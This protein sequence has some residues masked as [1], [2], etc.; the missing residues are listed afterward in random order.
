MPDAAWAVS[1]I[2]QADPGGMTTLFIALSATRRNS[3]IQVRRHA[4]IV[5]EAVTDG[6]GTYWP[7]V[8]GSR[9][10][11]EAGRDGF[12]LARW[13]VA[14]GIEAHG[15][16]SAEHF[17]VGTSTSRQR[18]IRIDAAMGIACFLGWLRR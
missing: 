18:R 17:S 14:R 15:V 6:D 4:V 5:D 13:L 11:Y 12:W 7:T 16:R 9:S 1:G 2:P 3:W 10:A 8:A